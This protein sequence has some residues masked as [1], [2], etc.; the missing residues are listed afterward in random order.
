MLILFGQLKSLS[1]AF[2]GTG[3]IFSREIKFGQLFM[4][5]LFR[6][7]LKLELVNDEQRLLVGF[8]RLGGVSLDTVGLAET[9]ERLRRVVRYF[10]DAR[11]VGVAAPFNKRQLRFLSLQSV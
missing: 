10:R 5:L 6:T 4:V 8:D 2:P 7:A 11:S 1:G 3:E 9:L